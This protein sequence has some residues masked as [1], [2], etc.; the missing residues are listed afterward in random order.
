M[1][2]GTRKSGFSGKSLMTTYGQ[3]P[4]AGKAAVLQGLLLLLLR[5][6]S[7]FYSTTFFG[8]FPRAQDEE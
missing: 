8:I 3:S 7:F 1:G 6:P 2:E 5:E 4:I